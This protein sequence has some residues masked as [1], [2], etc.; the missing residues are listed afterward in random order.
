ML[1][2]NEDSGYA[3]TLAL[4]ISERLQSSSTENLFDM[5]NI[6]ITFGT[7]TAP[8]DS[9]DPIMLLQLATMAKNQALLESILIV[10]AAELNLESA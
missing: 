5:R 8:F 10:S 1:L 7:A 9:S 6:R 3:N 4:T 2:P